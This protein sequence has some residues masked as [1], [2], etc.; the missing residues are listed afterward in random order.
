MT[1]IIMVRFLAIVLI[2]TSIALFVQTW[3][4]K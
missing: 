3:R 1:D 4:I 2:I